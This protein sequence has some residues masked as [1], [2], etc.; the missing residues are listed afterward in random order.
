PRKA[1]TRMISLSIAPTSREGRLGVGPGLDLRPDRLVLV[2]GDD[3]PG[4]AEVDAVHFAVGVM[5]LEGRRVGLVFEV[6]CR[7]PAV[8]GV[9]V[10]CGKDRSSAGVEPGEAGV[11]V[12]DVPDNF[13]IVVLVL[14]LR[15]V[16]LAGLFHTG[17][18]YTS[19]H[20][21][22]TSEGVRYDDC[23]D[24]RVERRRV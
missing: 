2:R 15:G 3:D 10:S 23:L 14:D 11:P 21:G 13:C 4:A 5:A 6:P 12:G 19:G 1:P 16:G 7:D 17:V 18:C 22:Y 20:V 9:E 24:D 8:C